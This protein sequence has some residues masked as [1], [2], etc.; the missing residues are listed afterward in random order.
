MRYLN[1]TFLETA[2]SFGLLAD[3]YSFTKSNLDKV[4]KFI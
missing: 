2:N 1:M 4:N 3:K